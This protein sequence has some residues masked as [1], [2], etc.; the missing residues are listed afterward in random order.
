MVTAQDA[1]LRSQSLAPNP[2]S[3]SLPPVSLPEPLRRPPASPL[4]SPRSQLWQARRPRTTAEAKVLLAKANAHTPC[5][6]WLRDCKQPDKLPARRAPLD[7][8]TCIA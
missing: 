3:Y 2:F 5:S 4:D 1:L 8:L 7:T 6:L